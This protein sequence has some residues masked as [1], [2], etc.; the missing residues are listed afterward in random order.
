MCLLWALGAFAAGFVAGAVAV[1]WLDELYDPPMPVARQGKVVG[2]DGR[3]RYDVSGYDERGKHWD[4][5]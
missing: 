4:S 2:A 5:T 1:W 3:F